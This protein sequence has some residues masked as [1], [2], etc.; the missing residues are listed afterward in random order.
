MVLD[1]QVNNMDKFALTICKCDKPIIDVTKLIELFKENS[2]DK[3]MS[4]IVYDSDAYDVR[5]K[6]NVSGSIDLVWNMIELKD[7]PHKDT[8]SGYL[9]A[10]QYKKMTGVCLYST[11]VSSDAI[12][13]SEDFINIDEVYILNCVKRA[14]KFANL[15]EV[16][17][18]D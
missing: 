1:I 4:I 12:N 18:K 14:I 7:I 8:Y 15:L 17:I 11:N 16:K 3:E 6:G 5:I 10:D 13:N 2:L 9:N